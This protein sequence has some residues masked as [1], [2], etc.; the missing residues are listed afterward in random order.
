[1]TKITVVSRDGVADDR[2]R[3]YILK[4]L[5][6]L[7]RF[8]PREARRDSRITVTVRSLSEG[9]KT[10]AEC[11]ADLEMVSTELRATEATV[12]MYAS[13]DIVEAKLRR[14]LQRAKGKN[15]NKRKRRIDKLL[16]KLRSH[17]P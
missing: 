13:V 16:V 4:R 1:M 6:R 8:I 12:N 15:I 3:R 2:L 10:S 9:G 14:Q 5:I 11:T 7:R 17:E